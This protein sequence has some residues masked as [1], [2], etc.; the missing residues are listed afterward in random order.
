MEKL[1]NNHF[2][3]ISK[4]QIDNL[5]LGAKILFA[6]DCTVQKQFSTVDLW[7]IQRM[8]KTMLNRRNH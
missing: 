1:T 7:S 4:E 8:Y 2:N 5:T 3:F 6:V